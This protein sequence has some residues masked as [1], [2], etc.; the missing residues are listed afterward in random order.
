MRTFN[1]IL[2]VFKAEFMKKLG[3]KNLSAAN[4]CWNTS[5]NG[6]SWSAISSA[7]RFAEQI[8]TDDIIL[9]VKNQGVINRSKYSVKT[10]LNRF[11]FKSDGY[12]LG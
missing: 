3:T 2:S 7:N 6:Y 9:F 12:V 1:D 11:F 10:F 5:P 8:D 4:S